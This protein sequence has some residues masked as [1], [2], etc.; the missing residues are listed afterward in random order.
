MSLILT[1]THMVNLAYHAKKILFSLTVWYVSRSGWS[2]P[3]PTIPPCKCPQIKLYQTILSKVFWEIFFKVVGELI[4]IRY[5]SVWGSSNDF[6]SLVTFLQHDI[7]LYRPSRCS[8]IEEHPFFPVPNLRMKSWSTV[9]VCHRWFP[10]MT[11]PLVMTNS[12]PWYRWP[13]EIDGLPIRH[14]DF[15]WRTVK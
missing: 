5:L 3:P 4:S 2:G 15:P 12:L 6:W 8:H 1:H 10:E 9:C 14:G 11:Y 13:I 7:D